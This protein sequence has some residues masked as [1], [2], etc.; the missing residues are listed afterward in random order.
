V[1]HPVALSS[2]AEA[3]WPLASVASSPCGRCLRPDRVWLPARYVAPSPCGFWPAP[4]GP[5]GSQPT[6]LTISS[7]HSSKWQS[8]SIPGQGVDAALSTVGGLVLSVRVAIKAVRARRIKAGVA[9]TK[10]KMASRRSRP[11]AIRE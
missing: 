5:R 2:A 4:P 11:Q 8:A 1:P 9:S 6:W 3:L 7:W 10:A